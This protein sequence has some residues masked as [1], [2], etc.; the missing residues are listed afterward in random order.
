LP[1]GSELDTV[2]DASAGLTRMEAENAFSLSLVRHGRIASEAVWELK[3]GMLKKSG[4][5]ELYRG[6]EDFSSIG[7]LDALKAA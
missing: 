2:L 1:E 7:G 5:V 3:S 6:D 4:L